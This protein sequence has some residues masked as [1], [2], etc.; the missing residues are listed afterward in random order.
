[1][2][3]KHVG[4]GLAVVVLA[5]SGSVTADC[6]AKVAATQVEIEHLIDQNTGEVLS[7][8]AHTQLTIM[9]LD[10]CRERQVGSS[11][12]EGAQKNTFTTEGLNPKTEVDEA[13][14]TTTLFGLEVKPKGSRAKFKRLGKK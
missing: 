6:A 11:A 4:W 1:M 10:L 12:V 3:V 14:K 13:D 8:I 7:D 5:T 9:L 2:R